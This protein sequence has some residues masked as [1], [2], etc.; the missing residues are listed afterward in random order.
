MHDVKILSKLINKGDKG[1]EIL[2][3][4]ISAPQPGDDLSPTL[5][6]ELWGTAVE[7]AV[8]GGVLGR[9]RS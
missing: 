9:S 3:A 1:N 5:H 2:F 7:D 6:G 4:I 8:V